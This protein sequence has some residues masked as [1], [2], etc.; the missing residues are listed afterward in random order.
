MLQPQLV[1]VE[2]A[3][4]NSSA[5]D[6]IVSSAGWVAITAGH[7]QVSANEWGVNINEG[8]YTSFSLGNDNLC[9]IL[10]YRRC[11]LWHTHLGAEVYT[12]ANLPCGLELSHYVARGDKHQTTE[13]LSLENDYTYIY[14]M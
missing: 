10:M 7:N 5:A 11:V 3:G 12:V 9:G 4:W 13:Q 6:V 14:P 8:L 1:T 2:G